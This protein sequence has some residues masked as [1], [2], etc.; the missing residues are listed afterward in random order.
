[1][2]CHKFFAFGVIALVFALKKNQSYEIEWGKYS[3][4]KEGIKNIFIFINYV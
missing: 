1:M 2:Y 3:E 4:M